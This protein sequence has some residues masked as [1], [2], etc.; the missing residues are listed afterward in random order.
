MT[1]CI[2]YV[3]KYSKGAA[4]DDLHIVYH[5]YCYY[6]RYSW[7]ESV[8]ACL[9]VCLICTL[10]QRHERVGMITGSKADQVVND[11]VLKWI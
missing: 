6:I 9:S 7:F 3:S 4:G 8:L 5:H 2:Y 11:T 10:R 1:V